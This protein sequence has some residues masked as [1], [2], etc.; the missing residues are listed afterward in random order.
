MNKHVLTLSKPCCG[1][2][3]CLDF[4]WNCSHYKQVLLS[5]HRVKQSAFV[6]V[7][8]GLPPD[9][10]LVML[11]ADVQVSTSSSTSPPCQLVSVKAPVLAISVSPVAAACLLAVVRSLQTI[12][13]QV[14]NCYLDIS[15]L[16]HV[17]WLCCDV[18]HLSL[19]CGVVHALCLSAQI[20]THQQ[21]KLFSVHW[22]ESDFGPTSCWVQAWLLCSRRS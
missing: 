17:T 22:S 20:S 5:T 18:Q 6:W 4:S 16:Y 3:A 7:L 12:Q 9:D 13:Q 14:C 10:T 19:V 21:S 8:E 15:C 11:P 1:L 2:P